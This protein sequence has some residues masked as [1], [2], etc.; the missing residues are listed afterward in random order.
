MR[1]PVFLLI[2][3]CYE[4]KVSDSFG[5]RRTQRLFFSS[6]CI[7]RNGIKTDYGLYKI[8][9]EKS[10]SYDCDEMENSTFSG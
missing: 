5:V 4:P 1:L 8:S 7:P 9:L 10:H 3:V 6:I 2:F